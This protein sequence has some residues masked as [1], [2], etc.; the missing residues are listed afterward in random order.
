[1]YAGYAQG[2]LRLDFGQLPVGA[3]QPVLE[4]LAQ[5]A[6]ASLGL[7]AVALGLGV[8]AGLALGLAAVR[9]EPAGVAPWLAPL[10]TLGLAMPSFYL[11]TLFIA[12][13]VYLL[14]RGV[15]AFPLPLSGFGWDLHLVLP[16]LA[17][18]LRPAM[19]IAQITASLLADEMRKQYVVTARSVGNTWRRIRRRHALRNVVAPV[20][21]TIA[22]TFRLSLGELVLVEWLFNWPGLGRLLAQTLVAPD[23]AAPGALTGGGQFFLNPPLLAALLTV[24]ALAFLLADAL[25]SSLARSADPRLRAAEAA[26]DLEKR[27]A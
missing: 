2:L 10:A 11:G 5:A 25:A 20:L 15:E 21:L 12:A 1:L 24:F 4:A 16:A 7:L 23:F 6:Q 26:A 8:L 22:G 3:D 18:M 13:S 14:L 19:Q 9:V 17:L 27:R